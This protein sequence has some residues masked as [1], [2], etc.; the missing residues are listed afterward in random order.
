M[1]LTGGFGTG[2][3]T[4]G[5]IFARAVNCHNPEGGEPCLTCRSC[6]EITTSGLYQEYD[7]SI[8][9]NVNT[10]RSLRDTFS[11]SV[12][13]GY[14]VV[15]FDEIHASCL[16][17][18]TSMVLDGRAINHGLVVNG[19]LKGLVTSVNMKTG[20]VE[21]KPLVNWFSNGVTSDWNRLVWEGGSGYFT[22][23]HKILVGG[24]LVEVKDLPNEFKADCVGIEFS[25]LQEQVLLGSL[26]GDSSINLN[27]K[28]NKS[29][30]QFQQGFSQHQYLL[31]KLS[32]FRGFFGK[33]GKTKSVFRRTS[34]QC[35]ELIPL[36][37][38]LK[39]GLSN[40]YKRVDST[41]LSKMEAPAWAVYYM[42]D[43]HYD[44]HGITF[45]CANLGPEGVSNIRNHLYNT[46]GIS[47]SLYEGVENR[48][49]LKKQPI[50]FRIGKSQG[51][52]VFF[53]L[54]AP[55]VHSSMDWKLPEEFRN[56][57]VEVPEQSVRKVVKPLSLTIN[58]KEF[59]Q[60][61]KSKVRPKLHS[62]V[63]YAVEVEDN[64]NYM[65]PGGMIVSNSVEAQ[66]QLL[67]I[68]EEAPPKVVFLMC[69]TDPGMLA[70]ALRSRFLELELE[71]APMEILL[72]RVNMLCTRYNI[73]LTDEIKMAI[74]R[75][76][77]GHFR[78]LDMTFQLA[79]ILKEEFKEAVRSSTDIFYQFYVS[80]FRAE[81]SKCQELVEQLLAF[82]VARLKTDFE[83]FF[84]ELMLAFDE[85]THKYAK[86]SKALGPNL[87][88]L[89]KYVCSSWGVYAFNSD[90]MFVS[91][92][93]SMYH[94]ISAIGTK[95][96]AK[97]R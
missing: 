35:S 56:R 55:Y 61:W 19:K 86:F 40:G 4:L 32:L 27:R 69:T 96:G 42:D 22:D 81:K 23:N 33:E 8:V 62:R 51:A 88:N 64:H 73:D 12:I 60:D 5:R 44:G 66:N 29:Y 46:Y 58:K 13:R 16:S 84:L 57:R 39:G 67:T 76:S 38:S 36:F 37:E 77:G 9:G 1:L 3:T 65:L 11:Y 34:V 2:K 20:E 63:R 54:I 47:S 93:W 70:P 83:Y 59:N 71:L 25:W 91:Y 52:D 26:I 10:L 79:L 50:R 18:C 53:G 6:K 85:P 75:R 95:M 21:E 90:S 78:S 30:V 45:S 48:T 28:K 80:A 17:S 14:K 97:P 89:F 49:K 68:T 94:M 15:L 82:P 31:W 87:F 92:V 43:G 7:S 72:N 24:E 74:A 41:W